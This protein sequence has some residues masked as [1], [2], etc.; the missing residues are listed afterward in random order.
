MRKKTKT[1]FMLRGS[2]L[3]GWASSGFPLISARNLTADIS[4]Y[5]LI[6][7]SFIIDQDE[8]VGSR[9]LNT[10]PNSRMVFLFVF[11]GC[12]SLMAV[13]LFMEHVM[14]LEPCPLCILQ[15]LMVI[16]TGIVALIAAIQ[17]PAKTGIK[18]YGGLIILTA[19]LGGGISSRQLWLQNLP[20]D[21]VPACGA[22]LDYLLDV[23]PLTEV[24]TMILTGDGTCADIVW[25]FMGISIPGWTLIGFILLACVGLF[26]ML[27]P[28]I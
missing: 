12:V 21:Q 19:S 5:Q 11:M 10:I 13:A 28:R 9:M 4:S 26:Q 3:P 2:C 1:V 14:Q 25:Q 24:L 18:I 20:E 15:R 23:F 7:I 8:Q 16:G 6:N 22:S 17:G 27:K